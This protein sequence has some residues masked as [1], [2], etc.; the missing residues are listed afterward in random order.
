M[1]DITVGE[2]KKW[3]EQFADDTT[4][5]FEGN[6]GPGLPQIDLTN[7]QFQYNS[8]EAWSY[9]PARQPWTYTPTE[10]AKSRGNTTKTYPYHPA[11]ITLGEQS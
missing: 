9:S 2:M 7:D 3:L 4:L 5:T 6:F 8:W 10:E 1:S 11:N